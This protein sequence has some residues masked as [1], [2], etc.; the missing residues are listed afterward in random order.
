MEEGGLEFFRRTEVIDDA[1]AKRNSW[2]LKKGSI[3]DFSAEGI[4][5]LGSRIFTPQQPSEIASAISTTQKKQLKE[6]E[7]EKDI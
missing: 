1:S 5:V 2:M 4:S 7:K 6:K 3:L